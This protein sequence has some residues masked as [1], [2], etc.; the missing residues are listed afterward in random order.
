MRATTLAMLFAALAAMVALAF[1]PR[2]AALEAVKFS[3]L[4][5]RVRAGEV[6]AV[7]FSGEVIE[8]ELRTSAT[9][10]PA[11][12]ITSVA[13]PGD[14]TLLALLAEKGVPY[15]ATP[16]QGCAGNG[17]LLLLVM[18]SLALALTLGRPGVGAGG[19][20]GIAAFGKSGAKLVPE[21]GTGV[22]FRDVAGI[23]EAQEELREIVQ[24]LETPERFTRLGGKIPKGVLLV[25]PP[26][27]GKTL[28][29]RAVAGEAGVPFF[30]I[31]GSD[32][33]EMFVGVGAAR[34]RDLFKQAAERAPCIIFIDE[35]DAVGKAR[36]R[37]WE[38][39]VDQ[40]LN[41]LLVEMDGFDG[42]KGVI[43][44]AATN[45][46]EAL[47]QALLR[48]GRFDRQVV[49]DPP[50]LRGRLSILQVH[51]RNL[52]LGPDVDLSRMAHET[53]GFS[54]ADLANVL[55]EAALL[56]A[57]RGKEKVGAADLVDAVER[58]VAGL[59]RKSRRLTEEERR[60]VAFHEGG[61][62][63]CGAAF[64]GSDPVTRISIIP[65]GAA[66]LGYTKTLPPEDRKLV[67]RQELTR[68]LTLLYG[69]RAAEEIVFGDFTAGAA[70]DIA[71]AS[72]LARRMVTELGMSDTIGAV[73][74]GGQR[75]TPWG[76]ATRDVAIADET[77]LAID[78]EVRRFLDEAH[79]AARKVVAENRDVLDAIAD[80]LLEKETL[81]G[82]E[83]KA[84]L[85]GVRASGSASPIRGVVERG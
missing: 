25:G 58:I 82:D 72:E 69:G 32:F 11:A 46:P 47:D 23:D 2:L 62:A 71:R 34:V 50:D 40:T 22:T 54:G 15:Q 48:A 75:P 21:E 1:Y 27:T 7:T 41:Q 16:A 38:R 74:Y 3:E 9:G 42:R 51:A 45:R 59:E 44:M 64:S 19:G 52:A 5:D 33:D 24:F 77:A 85:S 10:E 26:G 57:R 67:T 30:S 83:L 61:H 35:L 79:A 28:L 36:G 60:L 39:D 8:A 4:K 17:G 63:I 81:D 66:A 18:M 73:S 56:A 43:V 70:D 53:P 76:A 6:A 14:D 20:A 13:V 68:R 37:S 29:A 65:R 49:V 78:A 31:S 12:K 80:A 55:N 84:V